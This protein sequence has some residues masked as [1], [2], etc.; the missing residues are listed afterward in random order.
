MKAGHVYNPFI[1][2]MNFC[3]EMHWLVMLLYS[4][5]ECC[6]LCEVTNDFYVLFSCENYLSLFIVSPAKHSGT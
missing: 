5:S 3:N 4:I 6:H 2:L 1:Y